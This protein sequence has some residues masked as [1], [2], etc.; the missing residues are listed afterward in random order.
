MSR[1]NH[2]LS[3]RTKGEKYAT[4][5]YCTVASDGVLRWANAGHPKPLVARKNG[6][7]ISLG[8]TGLPLGMLSMAEYAAE[9]IQLEPGDKVVIF[10]DGFSEAENDEGQFFDKSGMREAIRSTAALG[11]SEMHAALVKAFGSYTEGTVLA[12][13]V[14]LVVLEYA[15]PVP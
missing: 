1:M 2:F 9:Q 6:E 13:D 10:S 8:T 15:L 3:D 5:F 7:L 14:T 12:D 4:M 11:C